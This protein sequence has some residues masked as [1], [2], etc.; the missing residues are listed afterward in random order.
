MIAASMVQLERLNRVVDKMKI[1]KHHVS[2][3]NLKLPEQPTFI[4]TDSQ[5]LNFEKNELLKIFNTKT[6]MK[7]RY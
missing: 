3:P 2:L 6:E 4:T 1:K 7:K 5:E